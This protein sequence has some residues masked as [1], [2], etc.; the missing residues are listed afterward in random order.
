[1]FCYVRARM[2]SRKALLLLPIVTWM[3]VAC[4][5]G[6]NFAFDLATGVRLEMILVQHGTFQ[7]GSPNSEAKRGDDE[8]QRQVTLTRDFYIGKYPITCLQFDAFVSATHYRTEAE[9]G[10][11]GG[12]CWGGAGPEARQTVFVAQ[13]RLR[14]ER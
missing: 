4:G 5:A 2:R 1:M 3:T 14:S 9:S 7:Q 10:P 11:S 13:P 6:T 12:L 8:T